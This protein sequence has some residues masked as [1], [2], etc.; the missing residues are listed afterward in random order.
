MKILQLFTVLVLG[1]SMV[2]VANAQKKKKTTTTRRTTT[3]AKP[4]AVVLPPL[5][6]RAARVK[7]SNQLANV[8]AFVSRLGPIAQNIEAMDADAKARKIKQPSI[9]ANEAAK[10]KVIAAIQGLRTGLVNLEREFR[11]K[12]DLR[13]YLSSIQGISD[14]AAQSETSAISGKFVAANS[15]LRSVE[16]K[17]N[18]TLS[19]MP[20]AE[21]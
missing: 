18:D 20:I 16:Q 15:P 13:K 1:V 19:R 8:S 6:V 11:T 17:L 7:V 5:E 12:P 14:L 21:L 3:A 4:T 10:K 9:D 2:S